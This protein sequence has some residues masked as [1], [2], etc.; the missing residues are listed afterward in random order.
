MRARVAR[1][2]ERFDEVVAFYR[3]R[4]GLRQTGAFR[5][6]DGYDGAFLEIAGANAELEF[7]TGGAHPAPMPHPESVLV[8]YVDTKADLHRIA[9]RI[10]QPPVVPA[11]PYWQKNATAFA[12]PDG[13]QVLLVAPG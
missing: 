11:N 6:H 9:E 1:H 5:D 8:L 4:I 2:T 13:F 3:D 12:D 7:T 10:G